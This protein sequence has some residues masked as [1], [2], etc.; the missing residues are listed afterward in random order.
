MSLM[1]SQLVSSQA[2]PSPMPC[3]HALCFTSFRIYYPDFSL[4]C[5][6]SMSTP[7]P[8][9]PTETQTN[10]PL[11][12]W[13]LIK[14]C[15]LASGCSPIELKL[16]KEEDIVLSP[17]RRT[18]NAHHSVCW[19]IEKCSEKEWVKQAAQQYKAVEH[20]VWPGFQ[21]FHGNIPS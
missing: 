16:Q 4:N 10:A 19:A 3:T 11:P 2:S 6:S 9:C 15:L 5:L 13:N 12:F 1:Q 14:P 7:L 8:G 20:E 21:C 17:P 18:A